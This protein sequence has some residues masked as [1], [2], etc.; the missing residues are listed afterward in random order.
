MDQDLLVYSLNS[1]PSPKR[2]THCS[3]SFYEVV[4]V[5][6]GFPTVVYP[7]TKSQGMK[8]LHSHEHS[9]GLLTLFVSLLIIQEKNLNQNSPYSSFNILKSTW[10]GFP[11]INS[12]CVFEMVFIPLMVK[13]SFGSIGNWIG[14]QKSEQK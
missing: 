2:L 4:E 3:S 10:Q 5:K 13:R 1:G 12:Q 6:L 9:G 7:R 8:Q 11:P 14:F